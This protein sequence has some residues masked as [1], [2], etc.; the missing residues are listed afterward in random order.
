VVNV[1]MNIGIMPITG[2]PL[3]LISYGG[4]SLLTM[5]IFLGVV[6]SVAIHKSLDANDKALF[7]NVVSCG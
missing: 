6:Q 7:D 2:I 1:G 4:S 5:M 3:P